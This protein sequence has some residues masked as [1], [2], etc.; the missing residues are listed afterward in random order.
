MRRTILKKKD[1]IVEVSYLSKNADLKSIL[2]KLREKRDLCTHCANCHRYLC[3]KV[4]DNSEK[5]IGRYDFI[6]NGVQIID[7]SDLTRF[8]YVS[9]CHNFEKKLINTIVKKNNDEIEVVKISENV[10]ARDCVNEFKKE[11]YEKDNRITK[12][13]CFYCEN[14]R[15]NLCEKVENEPKKNIREYK[16][17]RTGL[18]VYNENGDLDYFYVRNCDNFEK[19]KIKTK[20]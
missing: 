4:S 5:E 3:E 10:T 2:R 9:K 17:I 12:H 1:G 16:F 11:D 6:E 19:Q 7:E 20:I 8:F 18:Q 13:L 15:A 14:C